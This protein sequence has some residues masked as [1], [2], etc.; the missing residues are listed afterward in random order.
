[1]DELIIEE[2]KAIN[3]LVPRL[4]DKNEALQKEMKS[5][6]KFNRIF[7]QFENRASIKF[8]YFIDN[9]NK[10]YNCTKM[11]NDINKFLL[12]TRTKNLDEAHK[13]ISDKF[14]SDVN[15]EKEKQKLKFKS[16]SKVYRDIKD[17]F[18]KMRIPLETKFTR[19]RKKNIKLIIK[20]MDNKNLTLNRNELNFRDEK[21]NSKIKYTIRKNLTTDKELITSE[22]KK[23]KILIDNS[24]INYLN[25]V[26]K[27][28]RLEEK[29]INKTPPMQI[30]SSRLSRKKKLN[31]KLPNIKLLNYQY[32]HRNIKE[33]EEDRRYK[34]DK[35]K[36]DISKLL[37]YSNMNRKSTIIKKKEENSLDTSE[38][39]KYPFITEPN[40][41]AN[42]I[43]DYHNTLNIVFN[44][45]ND[46]FKL[47]NNLERRRRRLDEILG[48]NDIPKIN[49]YDDIIMK[50]F[51]DV[52]NERIQKANKLNKSQRYEVLSM[53]EKANAL[54]DEHLEILDNIEKKTYKKIDI[55]KR[56]RSFEY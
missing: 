32:H 53:K 4:I 23:E 47:K 38:N 19:N 24:I 46:E 35:R 33:E 17:T 43:K 15:L 48:I 26:N 40:L 56:Q 27:T 45:A 13:I 25:I 22:L 36:I 34:L 5:R 55:N 1:M 51:D 6:I 9:S 52:K 16:I 29:E 39:K 12:N 31:I 11:G 37:P 3:I 2:S 49:T 8:N 41:Y 20:S 28:S 14:Y 7:S 30:P 42:K 44:S 54:V 18:D 21:P 50:S 10:R